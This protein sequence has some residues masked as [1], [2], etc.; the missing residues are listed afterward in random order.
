[1]NCKKKLEYQLKM[2]PY[3]GYLQWGRIGNDFDRKLYLCMYFRQPSHMFKELPQTITQ[4]IRV[5]YMNINQFEETLKNIDE[6][7]SPFYF[8]R[9]KIHMWGL[10]NFEAFIKNLD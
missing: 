10:T 6:I 4:S 5:L 7:S 8:H 1:M 2:P 9:Q 3:L